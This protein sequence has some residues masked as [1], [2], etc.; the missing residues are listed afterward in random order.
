MRIAMTCLLLAAFLI[1]S[2]CGSMLSSI[3]YKGTDHYD[4]IKECEKRYSLSQFRCLEECDE[5]Y[6]TPPKDVVDEIQRGKL[7]E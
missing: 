7:P 6:G 4:C 3:M 1:F 5:K 2:G